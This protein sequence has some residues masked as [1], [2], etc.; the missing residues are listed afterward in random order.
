MDSHRPLC[1]RRHGTVGLGVV[2]E[3]GGGRK[4]T[5]RREMVERQEHVESMCGDWRRRRKL[6][7]WSFPFIS[8]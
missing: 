7:S 6:P 4:R 8:S 3:D 5:I 1:F 2:G